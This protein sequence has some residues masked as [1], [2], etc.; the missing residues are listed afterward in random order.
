M[1]PGRVKAV[2]RKELLHVVRDWRSL[3]MGVFIPLM[4]LLLFGYALTLDVD[5][6]PTV[7]WDRDATPQSREFLSHFSASRYFSIVGHASDYGEIEDAIDRRDAA[8]AL[9]VPTDFARRLSRQEPV[10]V[11][12]ILD[13][14]D[15]NTASYAIAYAEGVAARFSA[16]VA[17]SP[18]RHAGGMI[19]LRPRVWFNQE[20]ESR[21]YILPGVIA[22]VMMVIG[23][24]LTS[25]TVAREWETGT[26]EQLIA[27]PLT[28]GELILG[29]LIP[30]FMIGMFDLAVCLL[31]GKFVFHLPFRGSL[32]LLILLSALF[33]AGIL[34]FGMLLSV[35]TRNQLL[36]SQLALVTTVLPAFLLSGFVFPI[37]NMP[38]P[39]RAVTHVV[40]ARYYISILRGI[41][42][43]ATGLPSLLSE[44][45]FLAI[46]VVVVLAL[47]VIRFRKRI[48]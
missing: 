47:A 26:M 1:K 33:L 32:P 30:Y 19:E 16:A 9:V 23:A 7:V 31:A 34:S 2:A 3:G 25:L 22:I 40:S 5:R 4:L 28:R 46:F 35:T 45:A 44:V 48:E 27:T 15:P 20:M 41:F 38:L 29:K 21:N 11:Q 12:A 42:L 43:K 10:K 13:G 39:I 24:L 17:V 6:I 18:S 37:E 36:S 8:M 14:S